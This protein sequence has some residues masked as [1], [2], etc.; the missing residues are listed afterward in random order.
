MI[1]M[2]IMKWNNDDI[3]EECDNVNNDNEINNDDD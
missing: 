1:M 2:I 3:N